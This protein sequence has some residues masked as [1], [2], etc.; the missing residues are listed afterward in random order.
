MNA[1]PLA[2]SLSNTVLKVG[3][4]AAFA[5]LL[6][7]AVLSL[8]VFAQA[9]E[10]KR[11]REWAGRAPERAAELEQRVSAAAAARARRTVQPL[12]RV[13]AAPARVTPAAVRVTPA[14]VRVTPVA[15]AGAPA[16][17]CAVAA[18]AP[19]LR[20]AVAGGVPALAPAAV[21]E[22]AQPVAGVELAHTSAQPVAGIESPAGRPD[23]GSS[24]V[25]ADE[26]VQPVEL[27]PA[28]AAAV[29]AASVAGIAAQTAAGSPADGAAVQ[30][31][32][33]GNGAVP[34]PSSPPAAPA[35]PPVTSTPAPAVPAA[36]TAAGRTTPPAPRAPAP[37]G[38]RP[39]LPPAPRP[40]SP[41]RPA[42]AARTSVV[43]S[44]TAPGRA[45]GDTHAGGRAARVNGPPF[46]QEDERSPG[47]TTALLVGG[48]VVVV[49]VVVGVLLSLGGGGGSP[50]GA[51]SHT[52]R[53]ASRAR[54]HAHG[55]AHVA[56]PAETRV[57]VLNSTETNGLA[58]SLSANLRRSG[59][60]RAAASS[61]RPPT[62]LSTSVVQYAAGHDAE[63]QHVGQTLG[64]AQVEPLEGSIASLVGSATVVVIA[65]TDQSGAAAAEEP[66]AGGAAP[67]GQ[68]AGGEAAGGVP[69]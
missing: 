38:Q 58:H 37:P 45:A 35:S 40:G 56:G 19:A 33:S 59:Y 4:L 52:A 24:G 65:G 51:G 26:P 68:A 10:L 63:A 34:V 49:A 69:Q 67:G 14:P 32:H 6:G 43:A 41:A 36:A 47:R 21:V 28:T 61:A 22:P 46:L 62:A 9:R 44:R 48:A 39:P 15:A 54:A 3:A 55:A 7:I 66:A 50:S 12:A 2:L 29:A 60:A 18:A 23:S 64:I 27:A 13:A 57:V 25:A 16:I 30:A 53:S 31:L 20:A 5:G 8:L 42:V 1:L 11:L 17:L